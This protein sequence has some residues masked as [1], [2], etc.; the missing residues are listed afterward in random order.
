MRRF[1]DLELNEIEQGVSQ[2]GAVRIFYVRRIDVAG[3][4]SRINFDPIADVDFDPGMPAE[5]TLA[6][7]HARHDPRG[8]TEA[9]RHRDVKFAELVTVRFARRQSLRGIGIVRPLPGKVLESP[10]GKFARYAPGVA[11]IAGD[12]AGLVRD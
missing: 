3:A 9:A 4:P 5:R 1:E 6:V 2:Q 11:I 12:L 10:I 7:G 8:Q